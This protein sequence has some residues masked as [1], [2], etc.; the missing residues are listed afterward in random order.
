MDMSF[1]LYRLSH[2]H[3]LHNLRYSHRHSKDASDTN[4]LF[5]VS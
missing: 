3:T 1:F 5:M 2:V 4:V